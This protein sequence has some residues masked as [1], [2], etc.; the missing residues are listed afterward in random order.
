MASNYYLL[1]AIERC[2]TASSLLLTILNSKLI[3]LTVGIAFVQIIMVAALKPYQLYGKRK[4]PII[5]L[6]FTALILTAYFLTQ[7][8]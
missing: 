6:T 8:P 3:L 5:N 4:R 7:L 2:L 1:M